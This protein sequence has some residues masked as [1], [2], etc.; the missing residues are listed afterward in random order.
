MPFGKMAA[1]GTPAPAGRVRVRRPA[2]RRVRERGAHRQGKRHRDELAAQRMVGRTK[3]SGRSGQRVRA[4][5]CRTY[6]PKSPRA[7]SARQIERAPDECHLSSPSAPIGRR[8]HQIDVQCHPVQA[9]AAAR[10]SLTVPAAR[11][12]GAL[13]ASKLSN[14]LQIRLMVT[15][16]LD[17]TIIP[18]SILRTLTCRRHRCHRQHGRGFDSAP[19]PCSSCFRT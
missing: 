8:R 5:A 16:T 11:N 17:H 13:A 18:T 7:R 19:T 15:C 2:R 10:I 1:G 3:G 9:R 4:A 14:S 12:A 6:R